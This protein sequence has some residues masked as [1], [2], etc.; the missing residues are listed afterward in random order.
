[1][2]H[3]DISYPKEFVSDQSLVLFSAAVQCFTQFSSLNEYIQVCSY[4]VTG[5]IPSDSYWLPRRF[6]RIVVVHFIKLV[7][8]WAP[9]KLLS[10]RVQEIIILSIGLILKNQSL[11]EIQKILLSLFIVINNETNGED[12]ETASTTPCEK[13]KKKLI[14]AISTGFVDFQGQFDEITNIIE[15]ENEECIL[16]LQEYEK[17]NKGLKSFSNPFQTWAENIYKENLTYIREGLR[18]NAMFALNLGRSILKCMK[19]L[20]LWC[21]LMIPIFGH[22]ETISSSA[23]VESSIKKLKTVTFKHI[24]LPVNIEEFIKN[25]VISLRGASLIRSSANSHL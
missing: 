17:E 24:E 14:Q 22:G 21:G 15:S 5:V 2:I 19:L 18:T 3:S 9:L 25:H 6:T 10:K 4:L 8:K 23:A 16:L 13:E 20:P 7:C 12:T 11:Q 1:L